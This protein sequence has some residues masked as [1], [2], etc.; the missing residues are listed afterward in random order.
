MLSVRCHKALRS[1]AIVIAVLS[2][3]VLP[4]CRKPTYKVVA[5]KE[6]YT[7][8]I[9]KGETLESVAEKYYGDRE[10]GKA[11]GAYNGLDPFKPLVPGTT[12]LI[13]FSRDDL[14][15]LKAS[16]ESS[17]FY[18]KGTVLAKTGQYEEALPLLESAVE[19]DPSNVDAWFNLALVY[20]KTERT[21]RGLPILKDLVRA[22]PSDVGYH[23][24]LGAGMRQVGEL[25]DALEE[26]K[27]ALAYDPDYRDAQYALA[28]TF[29]D[30]GKKKQAIRA[31][32]RYL[33][34]DQESVWS[35]EARLRLENLKGR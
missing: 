35:Q 4:S 21:E 27:K 12:L 1:T 25:D 15:K 19:A 26:F 16:N 31:L 18:N 10:L 33:E 11:L 22:F 7:H 32:E 8:V 6:G 2:V 9:S 30:L 13:P 14:D 29:E 28:L 23:Y 3:L 34:L 17:M 20:N 24:S 5:G